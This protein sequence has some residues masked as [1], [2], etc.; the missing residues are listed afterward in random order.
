[1]RALLIALA[2]PVVSFA[3]APSLAGAFRW[4]TVDG[5]PA[6][7][8][9]PSG[10]GTTVLTSTMELQDSTSDGRRFRLSF[11]YKTSPSDSAVRVSHIGRFR[12]TRD[13]LF[14]VN[15][16]QEARPPVRF[17]YKW[18]KANSLEL[19]DTQGHVWIYVK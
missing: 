5:K 11:T 6:P 4:T 7:Q 13:S 12:F 16:G 19:T 2:I 17:R 1:M 9:F 3:Q 18:L 10:S 14:F 15:D 8:E